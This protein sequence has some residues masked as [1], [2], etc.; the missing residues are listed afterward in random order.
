MSTLKETIYLRSP[1][2]LQRFLVNV[3]G[4]WWYHRR[5]NSH[6]LRLVDELTAR[7][8]WTA[9][10]FRDYQE[11]RLDRLIECARNSSHYGELFKKYGVSRSLTPFEAL[12]KMPLLMKESLRTAPRKLL[13]GAPPF[14]TKTFKSSGTTGTPVEIYFTPEFH[15]WNMALAEARH[16]HWAGVTYRDRRVMFGA[17]KIC[18]FEKDSPPFWHF[19]PA[20]N[21]AYASIYHLSDK[22][23]PSYIGFLREFM[24]DFIEG[25][26]SALAIVARYSLE[27]NLSLPSAKAISTGSE[28]LLDASRNMIEKVWQS[29]VFDRYGAVEGCMFVSQC[30]FGRYHVSPEA[31]IIEIVDSNGHPVIPGI[32]GEVVCTG[33]QNQLQPLIRY[34][35]GDLARWSVEQDCFCGRKMPIIEAI[36]GRVEDLCYTQDGR[37]MLR[38]DTVFKGL[39]SIGEA[40]VVQESL[41]RFTVYVVPAVGFTQQ[42]INAIQRNMCLHVGKVQIDVKCVD[43]IQRSASGKFRAVVCKLSQE[44]KNRIAGAGSIRL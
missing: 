41:T 2:G 43:V 26:P 32:T 29:K 8:R 31:G 30:E 4:W 12:S 15:S 5:F 39:P 19:S 10:Q 44:E 23:L 21:L 18:A 35:V 16:K 40:Q 1:F 14:R 38:F 33:L 6:F 28:T 27:N 22:F 9:E 7:E 11:E 36:E 3:Y 13:T 24:P 17:R 37:Q 34:K 42:D 20:E 25:Y